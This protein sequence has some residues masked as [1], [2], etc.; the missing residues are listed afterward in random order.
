MCSRF[1]FLAVLLQFGYFDFTLPVLVLVPLLLPASISFTWALLT[2]HRSACSDS[3]AALCLVDLLCFFMLLS[4]CSAV[5][6]L[7]VVSF[8]TVPVLLNFVFWVDTVV[9]P[10]GW[11]LQICFCTWIPSLKMIWIVAPWLKRE[12]FVL[13]T[14]L[15]SWLRRIGPFVQ[16]NARVA[17]KT[18][19]KLLFSKIGQLSFQYRASETN[20]LF[21]TFAP[22]LAMYVLLNLGLGN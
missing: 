20:L 18:S 16:L 17:T 19:L 6:H 2:F 9:R 12:H 11:G 3:C 15:S 7:F 10:L 4:K 5:F 21:S 8:P 14:Y 22:L 13:I 1:G